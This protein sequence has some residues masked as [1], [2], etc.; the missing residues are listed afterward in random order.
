MYVG[1]GSVNINCNLGTA[2]NFEECT[3]RSSEIGRS[4][5]TYLRVCNTRIG[6]YGAKLKYL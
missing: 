3:N 4:V 5:L 6:S 1:T 2:E